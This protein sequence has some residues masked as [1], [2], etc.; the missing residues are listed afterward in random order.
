[1]IL[2]LPFSSDYAQTF[3]VQLGNV[4]YDFVAKYNSRS[5]CWSVDMS[6]TVS[7]RIMFQG[8]FLTLGVD[9]LA[10]YNFGIGSIFSVDTTGQGQEAGADDFGSRVLVYWVSPDEVIT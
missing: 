5:G 4:K 6:E 8:S 10:P 7:G 9:I 1:M 3:T 2:Q